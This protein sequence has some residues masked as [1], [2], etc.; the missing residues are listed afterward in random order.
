[1]DF[2]LPGGSNTGRPFWHLKQ[3]D[4]HG[5]MKI[6]VNY[7][8][9]TPGTLVYICTGVFS[10]RFKRTTDP[11]SPGVSRRSTPITRAVF[12]HKPLEARPRGSLPCTARLKPVQWRPSIDGC[13]IKHM[14]ALAK[15]MRLTKSDT[16]H[17]NRSMAGGKGQSSR[18][19]LHVM[20]LCL[21][22]ASDE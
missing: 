2:R 5:I 17:G 19:G 21:V 22:V 8:D 16:T 12:A 10:T 7:I 6:A 18:L 14:C 15:P 1:M 4:R 9:Y 3:R 20:Y 13:A 11:A